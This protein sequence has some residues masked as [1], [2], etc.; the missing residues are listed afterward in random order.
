MASPP[1][2]T[3]D[4]VGGGATAPKPGQSDFASQVQSQL[5]QSQA[6]MQEFI[7]NSDLTPR[8]PVMVQSPENALG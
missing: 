5:G 2:P 4:S 1:R 7:K 8:E 6:K 3:Q